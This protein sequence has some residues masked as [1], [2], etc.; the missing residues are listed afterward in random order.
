MMTATTGA[1]VA[2]GWLKPAAGYEDVTP[3]N[4][5]RAIAELEKQMFTHAEHLEFEEAAQVRDQISQLKERVLLAGLGDELRG[6]A[7]FAQHGLFLGLVP[8]HALQDVIQGP[9][10]FGD[11]RTLVQHHAFCRLAHRGISDFCT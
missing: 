4:L 3:A 11:V 5:G 7:Q 8:L 2:R 9:H 10:G 6:D 1:V